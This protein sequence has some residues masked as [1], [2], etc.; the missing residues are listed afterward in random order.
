[1]RRH[2]FGVAAA[3]LIALSLIAGTIATAWQ[4][5]RESVQRARAERH[6]QSVRKLAN[7]MMFEVHDAI[8]ALPGSTQARQLIAARAQEYLESL[9]VDVQSDP[10]LL[11]E[12]AMAYRQ[13]ATVQGNPYSANLGD[14]QGALESHRKAI[15]L[16]KQ[17]LQLKPE[18]AEFQRELALNFTR[19]AML[20]GVV[21]R[22]T[23][24]EFLQKAID[25]LE[26]AAAASPTDAQ[27][28]RNLAAAY[29]QY[30]VHLRNGRDFAPATG[31][32]RK[33][34]MVYEQMHEAHPDEPV[35]QQNV[36]HSHRYLG[37]I[38]ALQKQ[39]PA[40]LEHYRIAETMN[41]ERL[42]LDPDNQEARFNVTLS[43]SNIGF[44]LG[45]LGDIDGA[46]GYYR[47]VLA[48][49]SALVEADPR[50]ERALT[51]LSETFNYLGVNLARK[52]EQL[53]ALDAFDKSLS[54][55]QELAK[56]NPAD[57]THQFE[58]AWTGA[59]IGQTH[60]AMARDSR[61]TRNQRVAHCNQAREW[62]EKSLPKW[63]EG[64]SAI[65]LGVGGAEELA[66]L[67]QDV[68]DCERLVARTA[69]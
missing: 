45:E 69:I 3:A 53:N 51:G 27:V 64:Q 67:K 25:I 6:L 34:L 63:I 19:M 4:A 58:L 29:S 23:E 59:N 8:L 15:A 47:K 55:R 32:F 10:T 39:F 28:S 54:L 37:T 60:A 35:F 68:A 5:H 48:A 1:M 14:R 22:K 41:A 65:K 26:R 33:S 24:R 49:R 20:V 13:L 38:L 9:T 66:V 42:A 56:I 30:A 57:I 12:I 62:I 11:A 16:L 36:S 52:G 43:D 2:R 40:A 44:V 21:D 7:T 61:A 50:D 18:N 17:A 46:L 31:F